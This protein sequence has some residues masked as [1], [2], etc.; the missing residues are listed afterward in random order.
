MYLYLQLIEFKS[1]KL[2]IFTILTSNFK[3]QSN[4]FFYDLFVLTDFLL[5][6]RNEKLLDFLFFRF[7]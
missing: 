6:S 7:I 2:H 3:N 4:Y 5:V 1:L